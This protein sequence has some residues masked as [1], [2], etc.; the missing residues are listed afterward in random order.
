M[1][2]SEWTQG[3]DAF[4][5]AHAAFAGLVASIPD[6]LGCYRVH[7]SSMSAIGTRRLDPQK[8]RKLLKQD[9]RENRLIQ[10]LA[11]AYGVKL[12]TEPVL[13]HWTHLKLR[14]ASLRMGIAADLFANKSMFRSICSMLRSLWT[15]DQITLRKRVEL[16]VWA[17]AVALSPKPVALQAAYLGISRTAKPALI[18]FITGA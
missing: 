1:P 17:I 13:S 18:R 14:L 16:S 8:L 2:E 15:V 3:N 12:E 9:L 7:H 10:Q 6:V 11:S 5:N 4:L